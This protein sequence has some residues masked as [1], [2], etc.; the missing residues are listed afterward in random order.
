LGARRGIYFGSVTGEGFWGA[1]ASVSVCS[2]VT[3]LK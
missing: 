2:A 3:L 1:A